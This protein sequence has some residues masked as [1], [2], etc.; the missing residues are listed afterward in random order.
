[1]IYVKKEVEKEIVPHGNTIITR[2]ALS[3]MDA[4]KIFAI[5]VAGVVFA[6]CFVFICCRVCGV[7]LM[8][9]IKRNYRAEVMFAPSPS[10]N[11]LSYANST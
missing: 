10:S 4:L 1:M 7:R 11:T 2:E 3:A 9:K 5:S 6:L 8:R